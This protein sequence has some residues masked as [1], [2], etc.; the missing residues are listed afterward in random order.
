MAYKTART[1]T[2]TDWT[3]EEQKVMQRVGL[4]VWQRV[5]WDVLQAIGEE[6]GGDAESATLDRDTV[7][8]IVIDAS[9]PEEELRSMRRKDLLEKWAKTP[10]DVMIDIMTPAFP[11][12]LYGV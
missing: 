9:R 8:E 7:L 5:G 2:L 4:A 12:Q 11:N 10:Y 3:P 1:L 6:E